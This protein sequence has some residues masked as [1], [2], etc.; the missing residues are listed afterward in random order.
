MNG[1]IPFFTN[2]EL[3]PENTMKRFPK[4]LV[5]DAMSKIKEQNDLSFYEEYGNLLLEHTRKN[6]T[7]EEVAKSVIS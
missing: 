7:T 3:C 1:C 6:L 4:Q 5:L 2:L